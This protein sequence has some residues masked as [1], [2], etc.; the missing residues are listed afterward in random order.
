MIALV[1]HGTVNE[2]AHM[3]DFHKYYD[4]NIRP[5]KKATNYLTMLAD[6][7][8]WASSLRVGIYVATFS[9][10]ILYFV[11]QLPTGLRFPAELYYILYTVV[12]L[13]TYITVRKQKTNYCWHVL[14]PRPLSIEESV[15]GV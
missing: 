15:K 5:N 7:P 1:A 12:L 14:M 9:M 3:K 13:V 6:Q 2:I 8:T 4:K 10:I 11:T